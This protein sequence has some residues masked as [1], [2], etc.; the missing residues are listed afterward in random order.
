MI[1]AQIGA[2]I[3]GFEAG[4]KKVNDRLSQL[5]AKFNSVKSAS[6]SAN[7]ALINT[8]RIFQD[9][10]YGI[11]GIANNLNPLIE[12][13][14]RLKAQSGSTGAAIKALGS[15]LAGGGGLGLA[16]SLITG[17]ISFAAIGLTAF[18]R[19]FGENKEKV[20]QDKEA[21]DRLAGAIQNVKNNIDAL[22]DAT[23]F[24]NRLGSVLDQILGGG[25]GSALLGVQTQFIQ[26]QELIGGLAEESA[27]AYKN[28]TD[29]VALNGQKATDE[30]KKAE[31]DALTALR[32][33]QKK[34]TE[35]RKDQVI[36]ART[37]AV[38]KLKDQK[39]AQEKSLQEL[40]E[41]ISK[42]KEIQS[43]FPSLV[44]DKIDELFD[45]FPA[46]V[47]KARVIIKEFEL[48]FPNIGVQ[49]SI[50][51][52]IPEI[53][54]P[55][56]KIKILSPEFEFNPSK[57]L[58]EAVR[59]E[60]TP[61]EKT[62]RFNKEVEA[63]KAMRR[64]FIS[65]RSVADGVA[66]AFTE[67]FDAIG[68]GKNVF[69][70]VGEAIKKLIIDLVRAALQALVFNSVLSLFTGGLS[71]G[72]SVA[73]GKIPHFATGGL[74]FGPTVGLIGEGSGTSRSNPEVVAPL[75]QLKHLM[76]SAKQ[77]IQIS[78]DGL[79][80]GKDLRLVLARSDSSQ[81]STG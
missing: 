23:Q 15:S 44:P 47:D 80:Q 14:E 33:V 59:Q 34:E 7:L 42:A 38:Q 60:E 69:K 64:E 29:A 9:L 28:Y 79:V 8:G 71:G 68:E 72:I 67:I 27:R 4:M 19:G 2:E 63:L 48:G 66:D 35:A 5:P 55:T 81:L 17:A 74:V 73:G 10:P 1:K 51:G 18:S 52:T 32:D 46:Q 6:N 31:E 22:T 21:L 61:V 58:T 26:Q 70:A 36:I 53:T 78:I 39:E 30:T 25:T 12:S 75:D 50:R 3:Q 76:G 65:L 77:S 13:F 24:N 16:V 62:I 37:I 41:L 54:I 49:G 56:A 57:R 40:R 43:R 20:D 45:K 11:I